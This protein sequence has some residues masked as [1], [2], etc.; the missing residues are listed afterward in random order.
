MIAIM[1]RAVIDFLSPKNKKWAGD[2][3][4][5]IFD[6]N[7]DKN[8]LFSFKNIC[9]F[10]DIDAGSFKKDLMQIH[11]KPYKAKKIQKLLHF[12]PT[13]GIRK[14]KADHV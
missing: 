7:S 4:Q 5:W 6:D 2:A 13:T 9:K 8:Y 14:L 1:L 3:R 11:L 10:L 12:G